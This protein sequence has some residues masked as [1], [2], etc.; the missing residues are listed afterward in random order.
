MEV[1]RTKHPD[2]PPPSSA[3]LDSYTGRTLDLIPVE[4]IEYTVTEIVGRLSGGTGPG[5]IDSA[6]L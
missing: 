1:L 3:G 6:S 2:A 4:I 5:R